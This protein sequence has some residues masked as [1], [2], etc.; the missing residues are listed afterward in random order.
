M[1]RQKCIHL[2]VKHVENSKKHF[3][4]IQPERMIKKIQSLLEKYIKK[5]LLN[6]ILWTELHCKGRG[7]FPVNDLFKSGFRFKYQKLQN[8]KLQ[9]YKNRAAALRALRKHPSL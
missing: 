5:L 2:E 7:K 9:K 6:D 4:K 8:Y 3:R 1:P